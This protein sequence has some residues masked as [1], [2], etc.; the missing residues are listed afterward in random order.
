MEGFVRKVCHDSL[1]REGWSVFPVFP[2]L[3]D[4]IRKS[5]CLG[6]LLA[7]I[8]LQCYGEDSISIF[9]SPQGNDS[10]PGSIQ[11]PVKSLQHAADLVGENAGELPLTV[12]LSGGTYA[13]EAPLIL[14]P[15]EAGTVEAPV[16]WKG[17][18]GEEVI[19]SGGLGISQWKEEEDGS[20]SAS[21]PDDYQGK[22]RSLYI[23]GKRATR[24]RY[25]N[26]GY[27]RV[28]KAGK[29]KRTNFFFSRND[30][31]KVADIGELELILLHDWSITRIGVKSVD[32]ERGKLTAKDSIG[33]DLPFFT[34]THWEKQAR[35][36]LENL[37][38]FC[39]QAGEWYGDFDSRKIYYR[40]MPGENMEECMGIIP[41]SD[42]LLMI[43]G[44]EEA[45]AS[46]MHFEGITFEHTAWTLP[47][48]GYCG[49]QACMFTDRTSGTSSWSKVPAAIELNLAD[50]CSFSKCTIRN[51]D[52]TGIWIRRQCEGCVVSDSHIHDISGNG[53]SI[54]EGNDRLVEGEP[55]W[56]SVPGEV[57]MGNRISR[58]LIEDC[59]KQFY[60]A[61][62]IWCGLVC[63]EGIPPIRYNST[64]EAAIEKSRNTI[65]QESSMCDMKKLDELIEKSGF[66]D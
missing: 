65:L 6:F 23:N 17:L 4:M 38:E 48:K 62:G 61:V 66:K 49:I 44:R 43:E 50:H 55:W 20:W 22:F 27:L 9:V 30:I 7:T 25:P 58:S 19:I 24:S 2:Y 56:K 21:M 53:V 52:G 15:K 29:D 3:Q 39:D 16:H 10:N 37:P 36:Y 31:P 13:L 11:A 28:D 14:G 32:W 8:L 42:K 60:G 64:E 40:P 12:Y 35:Y 57:S 18:P 47:E 41:L 51:T 59:G 1:I 54:G 46:N 45:H 26:H 5:G 63:G 34:L 33:A